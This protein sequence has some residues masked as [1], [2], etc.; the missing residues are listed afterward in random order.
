MNT[1][2]I[3]TTQ[4]ENTNSTNTASYTEGVVSVADLSEAKVMY[5]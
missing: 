4:E 3:N 1:D 2:D 5:E